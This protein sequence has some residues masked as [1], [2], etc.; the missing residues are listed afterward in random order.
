M[1]M[2]PGELPD[3]GVEPQSGTSG[4]F[5]TREIG[6]LPVWAW[7]LILAAGAYI[8]LKVIPNLF[9]GSSGTSSATPD[10]G[11]SGVVPDASGG[12][13][14]PVTQPPITTMTGPAGPPGNPTAGYSTYTASKANDLTLGQIA[15][16]HYGSSARWEDVWNAN[17]SVLPAHSNS[18]TKAPLGVALELPP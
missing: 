2:D 9:G 12:T 10:T 5:L 14:G 8:G 7:G 11:T 1:A 16:N 3:P 4:N 13:I 17:R 15:N 6:G 18:G